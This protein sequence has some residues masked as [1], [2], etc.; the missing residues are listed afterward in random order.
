MKLNVTFILLILLSVAACRN[1]KGPLPVAA[2][3]KTAT[4]AGGPCDSTVYFAEEISPL[5]T[6]KC[7]SSGCHTAGGQSPDLSNYTSIKLSKDRV[8]IRSDERTM[9]PAGSATLTDTELQ[10]L[11]CWIKQG[12]PN[13]AKDP[14]KAAAAVDPCAKP[15]SY[16]NT[17]APIISANCSSASCH[18]AGAA[19]SLD[20]STY[21]GIQT[22]A[23]NQVLYTRVVTNNNFHPTVTV[24]PPL[25]ADQINKISCWVQQ[26][27]P[28]N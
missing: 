27:A 12:C 23:T 16:A 21:A 15:V 11:D 24:Y 28:N 17:V 19:S 14:A 6:T 7:A 25:N 9:P 13:N 3:A 4:G 20:F 5:I 18:G 26:G 1:D 22:D 10:K 8:Q 2:T